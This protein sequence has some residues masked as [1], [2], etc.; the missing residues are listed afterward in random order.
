LDVGNTRVGIAVSD[1]DGVHDVQHVPVAEPETWPAALHAVWT[2]MGGAA[3]RGAV[4]GSVNPA[5]A[6]RLRPLLTEL[7]DQPPLSV[8]DDLSLPMELLIDNPA[9]VGVDRVCCAAAAFDHLKTA[10][11]VAS[12]GTATTVDCVSAAGKFLGG[13]ILPG[14]DMAFDAL[15]DHTAQLPHVEYTSP[16]SAFGRN[17]SEAIVN[18]VAYGTVGALREIVERF[19]AELGQWPQLVITGGNALVVREL[20]DF[21]DA[22]VPHLCLMGI[23]LTYRR[24]AGQ[25]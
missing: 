14:F 5:A 12:F 7:C 20:A 15:H 17:T 10:C 2:A 13:A 19:A 9:E 25:P 8:R 24:A 4:L 16:T 3:R 1:E 21:V 18:G 6:A 22:V 23:A 11:A